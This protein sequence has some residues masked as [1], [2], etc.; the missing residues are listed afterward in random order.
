MVHQRPFRRRDRPGIS[1]LEEVMTSGIVVI[2]TLYTIRQLAE[3]YLPRS[4]VIDRLR[5]VV[6]FVE[7]PHDL[8]SDFRARDDGSRVDGGCVA[9]GKATAAA[10]YVDIFGSEDRECFEPELV[11]G[12]G[13][14]GDIA[15]V[16]EVLR[17]GA[18]DYEAIE[19][20]WV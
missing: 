17:G 18:I 5:D 13:V 7:R 9:H 16:L 4:V 3:K 10:C 11:V 12:T 6:S 19:D 8:E 15:D 2:Q 1:N 20:V 14:A